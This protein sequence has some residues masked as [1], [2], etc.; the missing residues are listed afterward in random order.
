[1]ELINDH[2]LEESGKVKRRHHMSDDLPESFSL[3][4]ILAE[5]CMHNKEGL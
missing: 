1:M 2:Q 3:A 5:Q 4:A